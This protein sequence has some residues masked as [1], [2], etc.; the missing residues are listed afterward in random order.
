MPR[1]SGAHSGTKRL[2]FLYSSTPRQTKSPDRGVRGQFPI[3][4]TFLWPRSFGIAVFNSGSLLPTPAKLAGFKPVPANSGQVSQG[5]IAETD[6]S[7]GAAGSG[8]RLPLGREARQ[9]QQSQS[10]EIRHLKAEL[11]RVTEERDILKKAAAYFAKES[12]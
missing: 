7:R 4:T 12:R 2:S 3:S 5:R 6:D 9:E 1:E 8:V 10:V 11:K